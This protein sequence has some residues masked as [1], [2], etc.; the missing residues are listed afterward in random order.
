MTRW[1]LRYFSRRSGFDYI[2]NDALTRDGGLEGAL[3]GED[4]VHDVL[5]DLVRRGRARGD[6]DDDVAG[7]EP[8]V[9]GDELAVGELVGDGVGVGV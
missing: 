7:G 5:D 1:R 9:G 4:D 6:A 3:G 8:T 2:I